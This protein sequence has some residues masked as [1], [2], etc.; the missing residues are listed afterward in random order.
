MLGIL[1]EAVY[2]CKLRR[3]MYED[4]SPIDKE[5]TTLV[6]FAVNSVSG[7]WCCIVVWCIVEWCMLEWGM[8]EWQ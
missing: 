1:S 3:L 4:N 2:Q 8:V 5:G 6:H 7:W